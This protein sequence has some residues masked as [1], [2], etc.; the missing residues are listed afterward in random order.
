MY[1]TLSQHRIPA[2]S[3][4]DSIACQ[5]QRLR[6]LMPSTYV[7]RRWLTRESCKVPKLMCNSMSP[8]RDAL[9]LV[10]GLSLR[11]VLTPTA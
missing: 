1:N 3:M 7:L 2:H 10:K 5:A 4:F 9:V 8:G 11:G 6:C